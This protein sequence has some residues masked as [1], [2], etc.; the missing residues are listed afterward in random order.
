MLLMPLARFKDFL[1]RDIN[2]L[3]GKSSNWKFKEA[4]AE[5][6]DRPGS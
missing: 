2:L 6:D 1:P 5:K 4:P 3:I